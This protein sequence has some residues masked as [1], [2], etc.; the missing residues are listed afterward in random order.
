MTVTVIDGQLKVT[1][2]DTETVKYNIDLVFFEK[3]SKE[4]A[5]S[6]VK[7]LKRAAKTVG[8]NTAAEVF[9]IEI[10]PVFSGGC[11]IYF[12]PKTQ[13][14]TFVKA[15]AKGYTAFEFQTTEALLSACEFLYRNEATRYLASDIY[16]YQDKYRLF[17]KNISSDLKRQITREFADGSIQSRLERSKTLE[18]GKPIALKNAIYIVGSAMCKE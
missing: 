7:L 17:V 2:T 12:I 3:D 5:D 4:S 15:T 6:L 14:A 18:Y 16:K 10:Y 9:E 11:E 8:F 1:L 13:K